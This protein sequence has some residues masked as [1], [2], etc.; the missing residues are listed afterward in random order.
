MYID[1]LHFPLIP[2]R[3][4]LSMI[5]T[6][7]PCVPCQGLYNISPK[8][9]PNIMYAST[10]LWYCIIVSITFCMFML[11][12]SICMCMYFICLPL[13]ADDR[14]QKPGF[15]LLYFHYHFCFLAGLHDVQTAHKM[16]NDGRAD[17]L[18]LGYLL[19]AINSSPISNLPFLK[20]CTVVMG[21]LKI[22]MCLFFLK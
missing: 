12:G 19:C 8:L 11:S 22:C 4:C 14:S 1:V 13:V 9:C 5:M 20:L 15:H 17:A 2:L 16:V 7:P 18:V 6:P 10:Q 3:M 21:T